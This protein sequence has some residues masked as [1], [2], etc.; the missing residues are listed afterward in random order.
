[1][2]RIPS[3]ASSVGLTEAGELANAAQNPKEGAMQKIPK[4]AMNALKG[5]A[6]GLSDASKLAVACKDLLPLLKTMFG[7]P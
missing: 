5:I 3:L 4:G 7:L 1:M 2:S 6:A